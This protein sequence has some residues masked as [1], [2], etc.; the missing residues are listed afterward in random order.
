MQQKA[1][2]GNLVLAESLAHL[3]TPMGYLPQSSLMLAC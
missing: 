1:V 3:S 2:P